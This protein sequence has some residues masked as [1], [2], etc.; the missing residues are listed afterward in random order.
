MGTVSRTLN[1]WRE[2]LD[3]I[4]QEEGAPQSSAR[5]KEKTRGARIRE[6]AASH[7]FELAFLFLMGCFLFFLAWILPF[8][9]GPDEKMRYLI[10]QYIYRH[11]TLP[12]GYDPEIRNDLWGISYGFHPILPY[13]FGGYLMKLVGLFTTSEHA[14]LMA[15]R[16]VNVVLGV[17]FYWYVLQIAKLLFRKN[18]FRVY[19]VALLAMLPQLLY[20][21]VYVNTD[22][23]ALFSSAMIVNYWLVG[24][25]ET[26]SRRSCTGLA[27]GVACCALSYYNAYG[28]ALF[29][30]VLFVGSLIVFYGKRG[31]KCCAAVILKRGIYITVLVLLLAGWWFVRCAVLYDGD[32]LTLSAPAKCAELYAREE[33]KPS[34][35]QSVEEQ[36]ISLEEM[37]RPEREGGMEWLITTYRS[38]IGYFGFFEYPLGLDIYE[39]H[40]KLFLMG[41]LGTLL[42][43]GLYFLYYIKEA[44]VW[45]LR[46]SGWHWL[47]PETLRVSSAESSSSAGHSS[48]GRFSS[49]RRFG[50]VR[51]ERVSRSSSG[52][53]RSERVGRSLPGGGRQASPGRSSSDGRGETESAHG[54]EPVLAKP[55][56]TIPGVRLE[57]ANFLLLQFSFVCC[58]IIPVLLSLVYSYT[59]DFQPQ[60]RYLMPFIIPLMYF[61]AAGTERIMTL[62]FRKWFI[63]ILMI[64]L[65]YG[66]LHVFLGAFVSVCIPAWCES[67]SYL[68]A[69]RFPWFSNRGWLVRLLYLFI[70]G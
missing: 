69:V 48:G 9:G 51:S 40:K 11:G 63:G 68:S 65:L 38:T 30:I 47:L 43:I 37:L 28:Y 64:P 13:I 24:L 57:P 70:P 15:A 10:P 61:T 8:N 19:F 54:R 26:W 33:Y 58:M 21:F 50:G 55:S 53:G 22:G 34:V 1:S 12:A 66:V 14:L 62:F 6:A 3:G 41:L 17:G 18:I 7:R 42:H 59:D 56:M 20:L 5:R 16:F 27:V 39:I 46:K 31:A 52:S 4:W 2:R 49:A 60:G 36:G 44:V 67:L 35:K 29:S 25:K 23:I 32:F 45:L